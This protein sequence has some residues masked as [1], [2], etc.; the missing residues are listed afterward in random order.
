MNNIC[1]FLYQNKL[2]EYLTTTVFCLSIICLFYLLLYLLYKIKKM[3]L[4]SVWKIIDLFLSALISI[5]LFRT[6]HLQYAF[7][8][9][10]I[11]YL[12]AGIFEQNKR[13]MRFINYTLDKNKTYQKTYKYIHCVNEKN[14]FTNLK[15]FVFLSKNNSFNNLKIDKKS[16]A[17]KKCFLPFDYFVFGLI[18]PS[19]SLLINGSQFSLG[20]NIFLKLLEM[21]ILIFTVLWY[22]YPITSFFAVKIETGIMY[23]S[24]LW[25][26]VAFLLFSFALFFVLNGILILKTV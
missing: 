21:N 20:A 6:F 22:L 3:S 1:I 24:K 26:N 23:Q 19:L 17:W 2:T 25:F 12:S 8:V 13:K 10:I 16:V 4:Y 18:Y 5:I 9:W 11:C 15:G 7:L 14:F